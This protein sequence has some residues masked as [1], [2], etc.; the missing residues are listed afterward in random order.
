MTEILLETIL[1]LVCANL[2]IYGLQIG[3]REDISKATSW[4]LLIAGFAALTIGSFASLLGSTIKAGLLIKDDGSLITILSLID[5]IGGSILGFILIFG[6]FWK[7]LPHIGRKHRHIIE[8]LSRDHQ[9]ALQANQAK[10]DFLANVSH[11]LRTPL[12]AILGFSELIQ[13]RSPTSTTN[14]SDKEKVSVMQS[15]TAMIHDCATDLLSITNN[16]LDLSK[17]EAGQ[18]E[19]VESVFDIRDTL[20]SAIN[21]MR[22][23]IESKS[24]EFVV[25]IDPD[26]PP[27]YGDERVIKQ[28]ILNLLSNAAK[29]T[30]ANG[31]IEIAATFENRKGYALRVTDNGR[32][33]TREEVDRALTRFG[34]GARHIRDDRSGTGLGLPLVKDFTQLHGG[35]LNLK[36]EMGIGT[37][38]TIQLPAGR[39]YTNS[40][41]PGPLSTPRTDHGSG[42]RILLTEDNAANALLLEKIL[43]NSGHNVT[44]V[45]NGEEALATLNQEMFDLIIMDVQ[46]PGMDGVEATR[47]IRHLSGP[48]SQLPI[49]A[50][51][52]NCLAADQRRYLGAGMTACLLKPVDPHKLCHIV[53]EMTANPLHFPAETP[54]IPETAAN[55]G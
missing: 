54:T 33:M 53:A 42:R 19:L 29:F 1:F 55:Q 2:L 3:Q 23:R 44:T 50:L 18:F 14:E 31:R 24:L 40:T 10:S 25:S 37:S 4:R 30:P 21:I 15:Y 11:E 6:G 13:E 9:K 48:V 16:I 7:L 27:L 51:T 22:H 47:R 36:S 20:N 38:L 45:E 49:L 35:V 41:L 46:M 39:A 32:G 43:E 5:Y 12:N 17:I 52:G 26:L 34:Q 8:S 28:S